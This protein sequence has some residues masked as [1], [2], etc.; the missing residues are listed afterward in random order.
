MGMYSVRSA[1]KALQDDSEEHNLSDNSGFW[2]VLWNLKISQKMKFFVWR[3][4]RDCLPTKE[5]L[6]IRKV[7]VNHM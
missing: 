6:Q 1:Y 5:Q 7:A 2:R 4:V 3:A